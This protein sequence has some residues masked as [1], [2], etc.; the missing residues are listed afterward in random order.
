MSVRRVCLIVTSAAVCLIVTFAAVVMVLKCS[1]RSESHYSNLDDAKL[2]GD[3]D[4][5]WIPAVLPNNA[6]HIR[7]I[8]DIDTNE[9]WGVFQVR[10]NG[11]KFPNHCMAGTER[12]T[13]FSPRV[14]WWPEY[15]TGEVRPEKLSA[16]REVKVVDCRGTAPVIFF[17]EPQ[18]RV[19]FW[20][21]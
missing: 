1:E 8:H 18:G 3:L 16:E 20:T 14:S 21:P 13:I 17:L 12:L 19:F 9:T 15:L 11:I 10:S 5:G 7:E 2:R 4:K 6:E